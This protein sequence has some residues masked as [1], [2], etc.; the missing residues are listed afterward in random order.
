[1]IKPNYIHKWSK[2]ND[3]SVYDGQICR[4]FRVGSLQEAIDKHSNF[5]D[6]F[7]PSWFQEK[8]PH[9]FKLVIHNLKKY[10]FQTK[11]F[12]F[13]KKTVLAARISES[14]DPDEQ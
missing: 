10:A 9:G 8:L 11:D 6:D 1:M 3:A 5:F 13:G 7:N 14:E 2:P 4:V 12:E